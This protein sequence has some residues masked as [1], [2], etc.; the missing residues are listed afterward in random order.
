MTTWK[1]QLMKSPAPDDFFRAAYIDLGGKPTIS[2][3]RLLSSAVCMYMDWRNVQIDEWAM[4][5]YDKH[6]T[7]LLKYMDALLEMVLR[8]D[9]SYYMQ[10]QSSDLWADDEDTAWGMAY[11]TAVIRWISSVR[12]GRTQET[13]PATVED[14][15]QWLLS[16]GFTPVKTGQMSLFLGG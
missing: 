2:P 6:G 5:V 7:T 8:L 4:A 10:I 3:D 12:A 11:V 1:R 15:R 9:E 13:L 16:Y 14:A